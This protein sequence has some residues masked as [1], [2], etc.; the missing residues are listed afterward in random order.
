MPETLQSDIQKYTQE[1]VGMGNVSCALDFWLQRKAMYPRLA[2]IAEDLVSAP[3]SE[4]FVE[5]IFSVA[6]M[7]SSGRRNRMRKSL[8]M[9]FFE[10][11]L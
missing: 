9:S 3:A 11:E 8:E 1:V 2:T 5:R 10:V 4:A 7:L 6:G